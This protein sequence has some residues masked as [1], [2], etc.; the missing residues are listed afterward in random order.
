M[1]NTMTINDILQANFMVEINHVTNISE[2]TNCS[3]SILLML[4][5]AFPGIIKFKTIPKIIADKVLM[6]MILIADEPVFF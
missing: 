6:Q 2:N 5:S 1:V 4:I 3:A